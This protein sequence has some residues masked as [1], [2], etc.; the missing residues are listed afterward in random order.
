MSLCAVLGVVHTPDQNCHLAVLCSANVILMSD[1]SAG[2]QASCRRHCSQGDLGQQMSK[3]RK[4]TA[5]RPSM[6][7][8]RGAFAMGVT[9][10]YSTLQK[11]RKV[12]RHYTRHEVSVSAGKLGRAPRPRP[13][14]AAPLTPRRTA[15]QKKR[16]EAKLCKAVQSCANMA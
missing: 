6:L 4:V 1:M 10:A 7:R 11:R 3:R 2:E 12:R 15:A 14:S 9:T 13:L 16:S 8:V 5:T